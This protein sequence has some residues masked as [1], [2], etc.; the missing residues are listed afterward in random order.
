V[1]NVLLYV[2]CSDV[3]RSLS[4]SS[5]QVPVISQHP[6]A[7]HAHATATTPRPDLNRRLMLASVQ[8]GLVGS[9]TGPLFTAVGDNLG[10]R[11]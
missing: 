10:G 1:L 4:S 11:R 2:I 3:H 8:D 9:A 5:L 7:A 6:V